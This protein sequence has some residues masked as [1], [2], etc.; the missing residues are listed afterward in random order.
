MELQ[1]SDFESSL[2]S[3]GN[4]I[5]AVLS[6]QDEIKK[7]KLVEQLNQFLEMAS[8]S[9]S[10]KKISN[11]SKI[12]Y[13]RKIKLVT[14]KIDIPNELW[15]KIMN[16]LPTNEVF[17][18]LRLVCK[19][20]DSLTSGIKYLNGKITDAKM[21]DIVLK[22]VKNSRTIIALDFEIVKNWYKFEK[23]FINEAINSCQRLKSLKIW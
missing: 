21:S 11:Y 9:V 7:T 5:Q 19:R 12:P 18:N 1:T 16:Y 14:G 10:A 17:K 20:F 8:P 6:G 3:I 15:T 22:I 23:N 2:N 13:D 4:F